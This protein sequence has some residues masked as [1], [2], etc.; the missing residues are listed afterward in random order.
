MNRMNSLR[1]GA[2]TTPALGFIVAM[3]LLVIATL[4]VSGYYGKNELE[5]ATPA[6]NDSLRWSNWLLWA[7]VIIF[8]WFGWTWSNMP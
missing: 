8:A 1:G 3:I 4:L 6:N 2:M 5:R 7:S